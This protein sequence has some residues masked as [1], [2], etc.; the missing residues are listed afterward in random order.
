MVFAIQGGD[1]RATE[2]ALAG[3]TQKVESAEVICLAQRVLIR[4]LIWNREELRGYNLVAVLNSRKQRPHTRLSKSC[5]HMAGKTL[6]V[7]S[8]TK[9]PHKLPRQMVAAFPTDSLLFRLL[10]RSTGPPGIASR[11][12][13]HLLFT[14]AF[15]YPVHSLLLCR[16]VPRLCASTLLPSVSLTIRN[17]LK[18][19]CGIIAVGAIGGARWPILRWETH[20]DNLVGLPAQC[21]PACCALRGRCC[22]LVRDKHPRLAYLVIDGC[23]QF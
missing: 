21:S 4:W 10:R 9:S 22:P 12:L 7:V 17:W 11:S 1:V 20:P 14:T 13:H 16:D 3:V 6:K 23:S 19:S 2:R 5:T 15:H 18:L 8:S